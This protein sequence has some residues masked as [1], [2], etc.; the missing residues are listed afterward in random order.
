MAAK[1]ETLFKNKIRPKLEA[2]PNSWWVKV[3]QVSLRG[4]PDFLGCI[5]GM[6]VALELKKDAKA[7]ISKLQEHTLMKIAIAGGFSHVVYPENWE[8]VYERLLNI[9]QLFTNERKGQLLQ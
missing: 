7:P 4:T 3:Q 5:C 6:F 1:P 9:S 8:E 2:I